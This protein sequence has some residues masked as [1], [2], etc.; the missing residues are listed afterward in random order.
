MGCIALVRC[1]LVLY[2]GL[3]EAP[4]PQPQPQFHRSYVEKTLSYVSL[5]LTNKTQKHKR[6]ILFYVCVCVFVCVW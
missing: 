2:C 6:Q 1:V 3:A 4:V 5:N